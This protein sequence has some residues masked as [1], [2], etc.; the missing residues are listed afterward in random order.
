M[1]EDAPARPAPI[2]ARDWRWLTREAEGWARDGVIDEAQRGRI[3]ARY[4]VDTRAAE[5]RGVVVLTSLAVLAGAIAV[6]LLVGYNW[7][8]MSRTAKVAII[9]TAVA[10]AF[11]ASAIAYAR[12][13]HTAGELLAFAGTL[14]YGNAI[15]LLAQVFHISSHYPNGALWW[16]IGA[17]AT[18]HLLRSRLIGLEAIAVLFVWLLME[19]SWFAH[20]NYLFLPF[21]AAAVWLA[22]RVESAWVLA[23]SALTVTTW[24][25]TS[26]GFGMDAGRVSVGLGALTGCAFYAAGTRHAA[27]SL[28]RRTWHGVG[29]LV[30]AAFLVPLMVNDLHE[31]ES[32][33]VATV[34]PIAIATL[35]LA[36]LVAH[37]AL[38][39]DRAR[40]DAAIWIAGAMSAGWIAV[41][42]T[43]PEMIGADGVAWLLMIAFSAVT[44]LAGVSLMRSGMRLE[45]GRLFAAGV[46]YVLL[47][48]LVRWI[49]LLGSM[50]WSALFLIA[51][52][53]ALLG[54]ARWWRA[55]P[56]AIE[57]VEVR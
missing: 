15:W 12:E 43:A 16:M 54:M 45:S 3:V 53:G 36:A 10:A 51:A 6:L 46:G 30:L 39:V 29:L 40:D 25:V 41:Q 42:L 49:D 50:L 32:V 28:F 22:Y 4:R 23:L 35:G 52:A 57:P 24:I 55:R 27:D 48:L 47:F 44:L 56:H 14:L 7:D 38:V 13:H 19:T 31:P 26:A 5:R 37:T 2:H 17:L 1:D 9:F 34:W 33:R 18:A 20:P 21:G 11:T 8:A